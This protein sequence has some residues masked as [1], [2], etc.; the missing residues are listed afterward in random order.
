MLFPAAA[1]VAQEDVAVFGDAVSL[2][3]LHQLIQGVELHVPDVV[4]G[5]VLPHDF[6]MLHVSLVPNQRRADSLT[7]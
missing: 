5:L 1:A 4:L 6:E 7:G 3:V 2:V